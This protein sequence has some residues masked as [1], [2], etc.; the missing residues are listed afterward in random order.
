M[1]KIEQQNKIQ[2]E[3]L[4]PSWFKSKRSTIVA[5]LG[6]GKSH[7]LLKVTM[8]YN[9]IWIVTPKKDIVANWLVEIQKFFN[10][11]IE[12]L[13]I[14][15]NHIGLIVDTVSINICTIG[16]FNKLKPKPDLLGIDETHLIFSEKR[17]TELL[18]IVEKLPDMHIMGLTGTPQ[19][20]IPFKKDLYD[21]IAPICVRYGNAVED[22]LIN[23]TKC[24]VLNHELT[25]EFSYTFNR[26]LRSFTMKEKDA[27]EYIEAKIENSRK[28]VEDAY[29]KEV[30]ERLTELYNWDTYKHNYNGN[31]IKYP[32][33]DTYKKLFKKLSEKNSLQLY[34]KVKRIINARYQAIYDS[35]N[36]E[37]IKEWRGFYYMWKYV[38]KKDYAVFGIDHGQFLKYIPHKVQ[39]YSLDYIRYVQD[40]IHF[41]GNAMSI[42]V[43]SSRIKRKILENEDNKVFIFSK[44][45][46]M[47][48]AVSP[49]T[50][51]TGNKRNNKNKEKF[52]KGEI[53]ELSSINMLGTGMNFKD[54]NYAIFTSFT[55]SKAKEFQKGGRLNRLELNK[56][57]YMIF[58]VPKNTQAEVWFN[59]LGIKSDFITEDINE[60]L[61]E[62]Y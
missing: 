15:D 52:E 50:Y 47:A 41:L 57:G 56:L 34:K 61:N 20:D 49:Y 4:L 3:V 12:I 54:L 24:Y 13:S 51:Y 14:K 21:R 6:A 37:M 31:I 25:N 48:D 55:S 36:Q 22:G 9:N 62:I 30:K 59:E 33:K 28:A 58:V 44:Y 35:N 27:Y 18:K 19:D 40:R 32:I 17:G 11:D 53:R 46:E 38:V 29:W 26:K 5:S 45:K 60:L 42:A 23:K 43:Y 1:N 7:C 2:N 39:N 16:I 8:N 10:N